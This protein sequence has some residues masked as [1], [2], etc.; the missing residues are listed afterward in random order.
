MSRECLRYLRKNCNIFYR[1]VHRC[2]FTPKFN[3][4]LKERCCIMIAILVKKIIPED[5]ELYGEINRYED[6]HSALCWEYTFVD[7]FALIRI[8][9]KRSRPSDLSMSARSLAR[10]GSGRIRWIVIYASGTQNHFS[11][12]RLVLSTSAWR[13]GDRSRARISHYR[14]CASQDHHRPSVPFRPSRIFP[15][16]R[17]CSYADT[18]SLHSTLRHPF[19]LFR[20]SAH[21]FPLVF[22]STLARGEG[23][24]YI[25]G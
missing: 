11:M 12:L 18:L 19:L 9:M 4:F 14:L 16:F 21:E 22:S 6:S 5:R 1:H 15:R 7:K 23:K 20:I 2:V 25:C 24:G 17:F 8:R 3:S 13:R 10:T